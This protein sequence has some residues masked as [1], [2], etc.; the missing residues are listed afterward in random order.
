MEDPFLST[1]YEARLKSEGVPSRME[2]EFYK[3]G[4]IVPKFAG[5]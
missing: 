3:K 5:A 1:E 2:R 4:A